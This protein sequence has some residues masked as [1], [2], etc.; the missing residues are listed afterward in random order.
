M[1]LGRGEG[2]R[3]GE[4]LW[5]LG[6]K[7]PAAQTPESPP[8]LHLARSFPGDYPCSSTSPLGQVRVRCA[9]GREQPAPL[10]L[11]PHPTP[12]SGAPAPTLQALPAAPSAAQSTSARG[13]L[14]RAAAPIPKRSRGDPFPMSRRPSLTFSPSLWNPNP[15]QDFQ[16]SAPPYRESQF[17]SY[18]G[19]GGLRPPALPSLLSSLALPPLSLL[20][21]QALQACSTSRSSY[22]PL[23]LLLLPRVPSGFLMHTPLLCS[24]FIKSSSKPPNSIPPSC[25]P[26]LL[27]PPFLLRPCL[28][29]LPS[30]LLLL[31]TLS[32]SA[33]SSPLPP[34]LLLSCL[35]GFSVSLLP[36]SLLPLPLFSL[37]Q[38]F[39]FSVVVWGWGWGLSQ[40]RTLLFGLVWMEW[41]CPRGRMEGSLGG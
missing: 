32:L 24:L 38:L 21:S 6:R 10:S 37:L 23:C 4:D 34:H 12:P 27:L 31:L 28:S 39:N 36:S 7:R 18:C 20:F 11:A 1:G 40:Q 3:E 35:F 30:P 22:S 33:S 26:H 14:R 25:F 9:L 13:A 41:G 2:G 5:V 16:P 29:L 15:S 8:R 17:P 19:S